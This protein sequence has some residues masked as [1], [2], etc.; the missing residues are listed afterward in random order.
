M[1]SHEVVS[2][3]YIFTKTSQ[4][5]SIGAF[6]TSTYYTK[7]LNPSLNSSA[8]HV[9]NYSQQPAC[10]EDME[11]FKGDLRTHEHLTSPRNKPQLKQPRQLSASILARNVSQCVHL[12]FDGEICVL[13]LCAWKLA[14]LKIQSHI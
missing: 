1:G 10:Q 12:L 7:Q 3:G 6:F 2:K 11:P 5:A 13:L 4:M 9:V 14:F 8:S